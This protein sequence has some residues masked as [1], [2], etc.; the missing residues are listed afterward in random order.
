MVF[1]IFKKRIENCSQ[2]KTEV[3][4]RTS[5]T[6]SQRMPEQLKRA[7]GYLMTGR[8]EKQPNQSTGFF[9]RY[10]GVAQNRSDNKKKAPYHRQY[11]NEAVGN[12]MLRDRFL[13]CGIFQCFLF[14]IEC[15]MITI[16]LKVNHFIDKIN[17]VELF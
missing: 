4:S 11:Q 12:F 15:N 9:T 6:H 17:P 14:H 10:G 1:P 3:D 7:L 2:Q 16:L 8:T 13:V 5:C